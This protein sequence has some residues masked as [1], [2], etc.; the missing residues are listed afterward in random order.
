MN[1]IQPTA[2]AELGP[3]LAPKLVST[4]LI[5]ASTGQGIPY[6][7][8][9]A[10]QMPRKAPNDIGPFC[11]PELVNA[12]TGPVPWADDT[13]AELLECEC[14]M[15][16]VS[17][18][19]LPERARATTTPRRGRSRLMATAGRRPG[20]SAVPWSRRPLPRPR[21]PAPPPRWD[22]PWSR[23]GSGRPAP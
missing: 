14:A 13:A 21:A 4:L 19:A 15:R 8:P 3:R 7:A 5:A 12:T 6:V 18:A 9:A 2:P 10:C 16:K 23:A 11:A 20:V 22:R 1:C 17:A